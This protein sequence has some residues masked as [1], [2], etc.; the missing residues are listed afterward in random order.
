VATRRAERTALWQDSTVFQD[1]FFAP[2]NRLDGFSSSEFASLT[3]GTGAEE[4]PVAQ[5]LRQQRWR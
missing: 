5:Q 3:G 1:S 2:D 4:W